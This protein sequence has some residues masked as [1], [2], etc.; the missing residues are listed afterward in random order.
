MQPMANISPIRR[1]FDRYQEMVIKEKIGWGT[2]E[3]VTEILEKSPD[4][5]NNLFMAGL[6]MGTLFLRMGAVIQMCNELNGPGRSKDVEFM[7]FVM[8]NLREV[9]PTDTNW[10]NIWEK[11]QPP[12]SP[13]QETNPKKGSNSL[14]DLFVTLRNEFVHDEIRTIPENASK[15]Q[16]GLKTLSEM[17]KL[18]SLFEDGNIVEKDGRYHW[19]QGT[20]DVDLHPF[21]QR[22]THEGLPYLFQGVYKEE[23]SKLINVVY[24]DET[25]PM[26][27]VDIDGTFHSLRKKLS[28]Y[29]GKEFEF[30]SRME[31]YK[32]CFVGRDRELEEIAAWVKKSDER[33]ILPVYSEAGKGKGALMT[34]VI[35]NLKNEKIDTL[36]HFCGSGLY[37]NLHAVIYHFIRQGHDLW[38]GKKYSASED[39]PSRY[40]MVLES[41]HRKEKKD[42]KILPSRYLDALRLFQ[43]LLME[44]GTRLKD[45]NKRLVI[46]IDGLDET[47][48]AYSQYRISDWFHIYDDKDEQ[49]EAWHPS[50][51]VKWIFT[52]RSFGEPKKGGFNLGIH[53]GKADIPM[54][55]P[56]LGLSEDAVRKALEKFEVSDEF[57]ESV[58]EKGAVG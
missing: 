30:K 16:A 42:K 50:A 41:Y 14:L 51:N 21:V 37:N 1:Y 49:K 10:K 35:D 52:Y 28:G 17:A 32:Q 6:G 23:K 3:E 12:G 46:I 47:A 11:I 44:K 26:A 53:G 24:G 13:W 56:L 7:K 45:K 43:S 55:Q 27:N 38:H 57:I 19:I 40:K 34:A 58:M 39:L 5:L 9:K 20:E 29:I 54:V 31:N 33:R 48:V 18:H 25:E 2:L 36:F 15:I 22:G 4:T 8:E